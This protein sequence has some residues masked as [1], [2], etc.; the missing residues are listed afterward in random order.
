MIASANAS[1]VTTCGMEIF[2]AA[3]DIWRRPRQRGFDDDDDAAQRF[4]PCR[5][6]RDSADH[7]V[8]RESRQASPGAEA[9]AREMVGLGV[10]DR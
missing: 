5:C 6:L 4:G 8:T 2:A 1:T 10:T 9:E 3:F 7:A